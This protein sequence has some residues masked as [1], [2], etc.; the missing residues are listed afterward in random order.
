MDVRAAPK[1]TGIAF[2]ADRADTDIGKK[3]G[4]GGLNSIDETAGRP[5]WSGLRRP[6]FCGKGDA[7]GLSRPDF[8]GIP[9]DEFRG[10]AIS[11]SGEKLLITY[12]AGGDSLANR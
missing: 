9:A 1:H 12:A 3:K 4:A 10:E 11:C 8:A 2:L 7:A 6:R 5:I